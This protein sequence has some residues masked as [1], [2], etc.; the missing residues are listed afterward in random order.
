MQVNA[1]MRVAPSAVWTGRELL[2]WGTDPFGSGAT[3]GG[4]YDPATD[5]WQSMSN[6][7]APGARYAPSVVWT[8]RELLVWG[9]HSGSGYPFGDGFRYNPATDTW[10]A[11]S[12]TNAPTPRTFPAAVWTGREL[13]V[14][15]GR[16]FGIDTDAALNYYFFNDGARYDP[17]TDTWRATTLTDAPE[18]RQGHVGVWT[19]TEMIV[20]GGDVSSLRGAGLHTDSGGR[21]DPVTDSWRP[22]A[23]LGAPLA[24]R[25]SH[26]SPNVVWT[27]CAMIVW[28]GAVW[29]GMDFT[30]IDSG[31]IYRP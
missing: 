10:R 26:A 6:A 1:A 15:G 4:R 8:G 17:A 7:G 27:G 3:S 20:W 11:I 18:G 21:Y 22:T 2:V 12:T 5:R 13:I 25:T 31:G 9:G 23:T 29:A 24:R 16:G 19:G 14:W 30:A 28:G